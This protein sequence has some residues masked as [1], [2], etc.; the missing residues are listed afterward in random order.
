MVH[1]VFPSALELLDALRQM[2]HGGDQ[3]RDELGVVDLVVAQE[4][5]GEVRLE[6]LVGIKGA[7]LAFEVQDCVE[8]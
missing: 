7:L 5:A 6:Q 3:E 8:L 4:Q 2:V 1:L